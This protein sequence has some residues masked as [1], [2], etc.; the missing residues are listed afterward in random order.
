MKN[1]KLVTALWGFFLAFVI[2]LSAVACVVTGFSMAVDLKT[3]ALWCGIASLLSA[4]CFTLPL[5]PVPLSVTA[6]TGVML[7]IAGELEL[8]VQALLYRISRQYHNAHGWEI[9]RLN[10]HT[11]DDME[12][13]LWLALC[14]VGVVVAIAVAWAICRKK[15]AIPGVGLGIVCLASCLVTTETVPKVFW[16]YGLLL[17]VLLVMLTHTVRRE[18]AQQGNRLSLLA[19]LPLALALLLL[20]VFT[21]QSRYTGHRTAQSVVNAVLDNELVQAVF[22]DL[23]LAGNSGSS[24]SGGTVQLGSVG[25]RIRSQVEILQLHTD[26]SG[27][28]YLRGRALDAYDGLTWKESD[29]NVSALYWP[30]SASLETLGEVRVQTKYAHRMLYLPYY[31]QS[32]DLSGVTRGVENSK[33]LTQYS[34]TTARVPGNSALSDYT[35]DLPMD[36]T[37]YLH[38]DK[39][40]QKWAQP[41][42]KQITEGKTGVYAQAKAIGNY[43][44]SS[45][46]YDLKTNAMPSW[47]KDFAKWFL[48]E[49]DTGYCVHFASSAV[50]LLQAAGIPARYVTGYMKPVGKDCY[51]TVREEDAHAWA[52]YW[53]PGFGWTVLEATPGEQEQPVETPLPV[54]EDTAFTLDWHTVGIVSAAVSAALMLLVFVQRS[55]RL[56]LRRRRLRNG[57]LKAQVLAYWQEAALFARCL[58]S[59]PDDRLFAIAQRAKFSQH[60]PQEADLEP[61]C[62][63]LEDAR[64]QLKRHNL[65]RKL[66]YRFILA[67]Y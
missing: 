25:V 36:V 14:F 10:M 30:S 20:F 21:P 27:T 41:L 33:K 66:Y 53:L 62:R 58:G 48:E 43:V 39:A 26:F 38:L 42:A 3:I 67:L 13:K 15:T 51:T 47:R 44:R 50:V 5:Q 55:V 17:G 57:P 29:E 22:G 19:A 56:H 8:S 54:P 49:S 60:T 18:N 6:V 11:A 2:S 16:L 65:F 59:L 28:L 52:E 23:S 64:K 32:M 61:F 9:L 24:V 35:G 4:V 63:Y 31:V 40:V 37:P 46:R 1:E 12:P 7:W 45:A 34:F